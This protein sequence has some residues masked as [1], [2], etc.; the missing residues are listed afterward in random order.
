MYYWR[1]QSVKKSFSL[2]NLII[3]FTLTACSSKKDDT[4][5]IKD[6]APVN[7]NSS[8]TTLLP[9]PT[10]AVVTK[11]IKSEIQNH[12]YRYPELT[13]LL[14]VKD[15]P[16]VIQK[17]EQAG[18]KIIYNPNRGRGSSIGFLVANLPPEKI[19]DDEFIASLDLKAI[20]FEQSTLSKV[21]LMGETPKSLTHLSV[22]VEEIGINALREKYPKSHEG[23]NVLVAVIDTGIDASHP[24]FQD[25][26]I[27]W[28]DLTQEGDITL[29]PANLITPQ[30]VSIGGILP[31][32]IP[33]FINKEKPILGGIINEK[34][35]GVQIGDEGRTDETISGIDINQNGTFNDIFPFIVA[36]EMSSGKQV[37]LID[38]NK[39]GDLSLLKPENAILDFNSFQQRDMG[40][41]S[42]FLKFSSSNKEIKYP[43]I[44]HKNSKNIPEKITIGGDFDGHGTHVAGIIGANGVNLKGAAPKAQFMA[45]KVCSGITC[46]DQAILRGLVDAFYNAQGLIPDVVNISLG[47]KQGYTVDLYSFVLRDLAAKFGTTFFISASNSGPGIRSINSL[48]H[49]GPIVSVG[50]HVSKNS[51]IKH[52]DVHPDIDAPEHGIFGF[53]S[54]GPNYTGEL[55]P[56]IVAPGSALSSTPLRDGGA[57]MYNGTSMSSPLAAGGAAVMIGIIKNL[58]NE[59]QKI[60]R[61]FEY[62]SL[63]IKDILKGEENLKGFSLIDLPLALRTSL[64]DSAKKLPF[65]NILRQGHGLIDIS[66]ATE[67]LIGSLKSMVNE[68]SEVTP[69]GLTDFSFNKNMGTTSDTRLYDK[70]V[71]IALRK[72]VEL[73][74]EDDG[75]RGQ[76][77]II[78]RFKTI[79]MKVKLTKVEV[80]N[81]IGEV[82]TLTQDL[83]FSITVPGLENQNSR[84]RELLLGSSLKKAFIS[85]RDTSKMLPGHTYI[86]VYEIEQEGKRLT[87]L[88][89]VVQKPLEF[90]QAI[91]R[92]HLPSLSSD[93]LQLPASMGLKE[94][95]ILP[96]RNHRIPVAIR[97]GDQSL[98]INAN[99]S[100]GKSGSILIN[101]YD[102]DGLKV[103]ETTLRR[104][105]Q[106]PLNTGIVKLKIPTSSKPGIYEIMVSTSSGR[107]MGTT[108]YD[109]LIRVAKFQADKKQIS[110]ATKSTESK[111]LASSEVVTIINTALQ[112]KSI[113]A[114]QESFVLLESL[115]PF[116]VVS[117][118][119]TFKKVSIPK[120]Q[121]LS[122]VNILIEDKG[123]D[124]LNCISRIDHNL[125]HYDEVL[126]G[127]KVADS[128]SQITSRG[129]KLFQSVSIEKDLYAAV[130][131]LMCGLPDAS[132]LAMNSKQ[133]GLNIEASF[134]GLP[135]IEGA[136]GFSVSAK[137]NIQ[138]ENNRFL[139]KIEAPQKLG[140]LPDNVPGEIK[141]RG[142]AT[143]G[144]SSDDS[145]LKEVIEIDLYQ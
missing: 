113:S 116:P 109:M 35:L 37:V 115:K 9:Q 20:T 120:I 72:S 12:L 50:A 105:A 10:P 95:T 98:L 101:V 128:T 41:F 61:V 104:S 141:I 46:S 11:E 67:K 138:T 75:E 22:P 122:S 85:L 74:I 103:A 135:L 27:Y 92:H 140:L 65:H 91:S 6:N 129:G 64:E 78:E 58:S 81:S 16:M 90:S 29:F 69:L 127:Y 87:T 96:N 144:I 114:K 68:A 137:T 8:D 143:I 53:S 7:T 130:E 77:F 34:S 76:S 83:P 1:K 106:S 17:V 26:V 73:D 31:I 4:P 124:K 24:A 112:T 47:S 40:S 14:A 84:E 18:G 43:V 139:V 80:E 36:E 117:G 56:N 49:F 15:V 23:Q 28:Q 30:Q 66:L 51:L 2:L 93:I 21:E 38:Q 145:D 110:L 3:L 123:G 59:D 100:E 33:S 70:T 102:A 32:K 5:I 118:K 39:S 86:A 44:I 62:K 60:A 107:W 45:L 88:T 42:K 119:W 111:T 125:Y 19:L 94:V 142:R 89:D 13:T 54:A 82:Q 132:V 63:K 136:T 48:G 131:T 55:R 79:P 108:Q 126:G 134:P 133:R 71:D 57:D 97:S 121:N 99:I 52:Y 25:R